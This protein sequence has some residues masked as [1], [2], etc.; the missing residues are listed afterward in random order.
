MTEPAIEQA[1]RIVG[2]VSE[3]YESMASKLGTRVKCKTCGTE[4][5]VDPAKCLRRGWPT[6]CGHTMALLD[7]TNP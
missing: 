1:K 2:S 7:R 5:V 6:C 4:Q 3:M